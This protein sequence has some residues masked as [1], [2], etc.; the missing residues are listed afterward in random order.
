MCAIFFHEEIIRFCIKGQ[1]LG[2][3]RA[4]LIPCRIKMDEPWINMKQKTAGGRQ[5]MMNSQTEIEI[6]IVKQKKLY[7]EDRTSRNVKVTTVSVAL[8]LIPFRSLICLLEFVQ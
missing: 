6:R 5:V 3:G 1:V 2:E 8:L 4:R 7:N